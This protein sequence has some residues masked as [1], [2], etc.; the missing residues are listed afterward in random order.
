LNRRDLARHYARRSAGARLWWMLRQALL[1]LLF[2]S[3]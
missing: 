1:S 2:E 3:R